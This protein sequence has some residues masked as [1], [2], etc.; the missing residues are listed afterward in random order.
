[1]TVDA[2]ASEGHYLRHILP[3]WR[4]M[5]R[6]IKGTLWLEPR[7]SDLASTVDAKVGIPRDNPNPVLV[8]SYSDTRDAHSDTMILASHGAGQSYMAEGNIH[9]G[10]PGGGQSDQI[11]LFLCPN[12][13][14]ADRWL[15]QY[16]QAKAAV[17]GYP[18][19]DAFHSRP[20]LERFK[21]PVVAFAFNQDI[22]LCPEST[23]AFG[24]YESAFKKVA[25]TYKTVGTAHP[26]IFDQLKS[27][28]TQS[29]VT[30]IWEPGV[31]L[32]QASVL[33]VDN[34]SV[35]WEFIG[36]DKPV[37][38]LNAPWYRRDIEHGLRFWRNAG[39]GVQIS[40]PSD[41]VMGI[42]WALQDDQLVQEERRKAIREV[43]TYVDG[44]AS[45]RAVN[46]ILNLV[47]N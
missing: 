2:Y 1:M 22:D 23:S 16:P 41:L 27:F 36:L 30:P 28:Y 25:E 37:V 13:S 26:R 21:E 39:S 46:A 47:T 31:I 43:I 18:A 4:Q 8:A 6:D 14:V 32:Q 10:Y 29:G 9:P 42:E 12:Q 20:P 7:L 44:L 15:V 35:G 24:H 19:L 33:L 11:R 5:P 34:S 38:W 40:D 45:Q 3:I 17:I